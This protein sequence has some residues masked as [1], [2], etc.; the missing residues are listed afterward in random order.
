M[1]SWG[2]NTFQNLM[3]RD[4]VIRMLV[5]VV[6]RGGNVL[7]NVG[8]DRD[9]IIPPTHVQRLM[10]VGEWLETNGESI[11][12]T[13]PGPFQPGDYGVTMH[14]DKTIYVH[15][16]KWPGDKLKLPAI[17]A[18]IVRATALTGGEVSFSQS[19]D[20]LDLSVPPANRGG[21]DTVIA[22]ELDRLAGDIPL[23]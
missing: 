1:T 15:V 22:L 8:P 7:L 13:R 4:D 17:P 18:K 23:L 21:L 9:G 6:G 20:G 10:E 3:T 11:Y 2:F 16:L 12:G 19:N 14:R 5:N